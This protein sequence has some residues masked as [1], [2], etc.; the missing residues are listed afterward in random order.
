M[1][2]E[3]RKCPH[4]KPVAV[5]ELQVRKIGPWEGPGPWALV[6]NV[7]GGGAVCLAEGRKQDMQRLAKS[8]RRELKWDWRPVR[9]VAA[10]VRHLVPD[11]LR[12]PKP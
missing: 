11:S 9:F 8:C 7:L 5:V 4:Q 3:Q 1:V 10:L 6:V 2:A 12:R